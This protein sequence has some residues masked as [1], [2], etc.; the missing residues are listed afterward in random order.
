ME[1]VQ[2]QIQLCILCGAVIS[3]GNIEWRDL[4]AENEV[5]TYGYCPACG[6]MNDPQDKE[7]QNKVNEYNKEKRRR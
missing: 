2:S 1:Q 4:L 6:D 3:S 7:W 5:V